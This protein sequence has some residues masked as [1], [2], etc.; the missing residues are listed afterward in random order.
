[1]RRRVFIA[2]RYA[3]ALLAL[4][5][6]FALVDLGEVGRALA[7]A[8]PAPVIAGLALM[9]VALLVNTL[10]WQRLAA[11]AGAPTSFH[12]LLQLNLIA[13]FYGVVLP[14][15]LAGEGMKI[16]RIARRE[17]ARTALAV[18]T[19][20]DRLTG[21]V[22]I[23]LL[24]VVGLGIAR[25]AG[26]LGSVLLAA[27]LAVLAGTMAGIAMLLFAPAAL[28]RIA[29]QGARG[30]LHAASMAARRMLRDPSTLVASLGLSIAFQLVL[31]T[32]TWLWAEAI[33]VHVSW[34]AVAWIFAAVS[35][36]QLVPITV[37]GIG[38]RE[39]ALAT[40]LDPYGIAASQAVAI[41]VMILFGNVLVALAGFFVDV[42]IGRP[43]LGKAGR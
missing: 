24:A 17:S 32:S 33:D 42:R 39:G 29:P 43:V 21:L 9:V 28:A 27:S 34:F 15:Q 12:D 36:I 38:P 8:E 26:D 11:A 1:M 35:I 18:S 14:G 6:L 19:A 20:G 37:A 7:H 30:I 40:L 22:A 41:G 2:I 4:A 5:L 10:K 31:T 23:V 16:A 25:P 13:A 3:F